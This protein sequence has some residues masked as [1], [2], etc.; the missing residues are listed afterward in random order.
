MLQSAEANR[1]KAFVLSIFKKIIM[2]AKSKIKVKLVK[3]GIGFP[4][5]QRD[6]LKGLGLR[7][8]RQTRILD[9]SDAI[10]GMIKKVIHLVEYEE[11][12]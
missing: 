4:Q 12:N 6:T 10:R 2:T 8:I 11:V 5:R 3:S 7:K 9:D 1:L